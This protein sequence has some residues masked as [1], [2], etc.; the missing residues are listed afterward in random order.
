MK[1]LTR[2]KIAAVPF[3]AAASLLLLPVAPAQSSNAQ[4]DQ[5]LSATTSPAPAQAK[6][7]ADATDRSK[8]YFHDGM[9]AI[10]EDEAVASGR[11]EFVAHSIEEYKAALNADPT[12]PS[13]NNSLADLYLRV[14][15]VKEAEST[16]RTLLKSR[17]TTWM[18]ISC[19]DAFFF[20]S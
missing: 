9:A 4:K 8:S 5:A 16:A 15:R 19:W 2:T 18:R 12:S 13:L 10:Y 1:R 20:A 17:R 14:G 11:P 3:L 7:D 6:P